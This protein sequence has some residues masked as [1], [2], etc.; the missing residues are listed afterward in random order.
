MFELADSGLLPTLFV[1]ITVKA[2]AV[3]AR[4]PLTV[5]AV[6]VADT[7]TRTYGCPSRS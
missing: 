4:R 7:T 1:A 3:P 6:A 5:A 2:Y